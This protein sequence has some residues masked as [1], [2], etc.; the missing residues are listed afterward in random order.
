MT[1]IWHKNVGSII[2]SLWTVWCKTGSDLGFWRAQSQVV[3]V[4][5][6]QISPISSII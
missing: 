2:F 6:Q 4:T 5:N 1:A 3:L